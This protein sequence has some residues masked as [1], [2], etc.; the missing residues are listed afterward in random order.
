[1][2][3][4]TEQLITSQPLEMENWKPLRAFSFLLTNRS[5]KKQAIFLKTCFSQQ[6][7]LFFEGGLAVPWVRHK[8]LP[9]T[10]CLILLPM[11]RHEPRKGPGEEDRP[12]QGERETL[13]TLSVMLPCH[14]VPH[15]LAN[16]LWPRCDAHL[17]RSQYQRPLGSSAA[18]SFYR[19]FM[20]N[21]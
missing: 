21:N 14:S 9:L 8:H 5:K 16:F 2:K 1:M 18:I 15:A 7:P 3:Y 12:I 13:P 6:L 10:L 20:P 4:V 11:E 17:L 19:T